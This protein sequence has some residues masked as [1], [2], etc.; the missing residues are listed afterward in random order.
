MPA[1]TGAL[2]PLASARYPILIGVPVGAFGAAAAGALGD[3]GGLHAV[4]HARTSS[5]EI[6][7]RTRST[8]AH[9]PGR[10]PGDGMS[11]ERVYFIKPMRRRRRRAGR[12][13]AP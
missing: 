2:V 10:S 5:A 4:S 1:A 6:T 13:G 12:R 8:I 9:L 7:R 3:G 11:P